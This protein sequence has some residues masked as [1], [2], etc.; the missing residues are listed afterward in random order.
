MDKILNEMI[1]DWLSKLISESK[2]ITQEIYNGLS[3]KNYTSG[4]PINIGDFVLHAL[5][6]QPIKISS[7]G[8]P[9]EIDLKIIKFK[10]TEIGTI[11]EL[12]TR[13]SLDASTPLRVSMDTCNGLDVKT[14]IPHLKYI[15]DKNKIDPI[16]Y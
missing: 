15:E 10:S 3:Q 14:R 11:Y 16:Y 6:M 13:N 8:T 1:P 7:D 4:E 9:S 2:P 12:D 5:L